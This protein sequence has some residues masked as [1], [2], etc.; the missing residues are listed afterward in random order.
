MS[1]LSTF[2]LIAVHDFVADLPAGSL[3]RLA[4]AGRP[5]FHANGVR[6]CRED[7]P[8]TRFW[9]VHSGRVALDF[10]VPGRGDIV[11]E[12]IGPGGV[13]GW[14]WLLKPGRW[15]FGAVVAEDIRAVEFDAADVHTLIDE[16]PDLA[17]ELTTRFMDLVAD[18]LQASRHRLVEL[19]AYPPD[20][21]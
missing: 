9:L 1:S 11:I 15:R 12:D 4:T 8:A 16:D 3:H 20:R 7:T 10:H 21:S 2:D 5:V 18:R 13:V 6:L 19:Y 17:R 14:S